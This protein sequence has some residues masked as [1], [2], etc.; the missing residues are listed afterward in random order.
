MWPFKKDKQL[1]E[2]EWEIEKLR[3]DRKCSEVSIFREQIND[4][5]ESNDLDKMRWVNQLHWNIFNKK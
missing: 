2:L 3:I 1:Q 4:A 5:I